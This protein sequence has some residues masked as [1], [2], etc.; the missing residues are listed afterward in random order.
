M[1]DRPNYQYNDYNSLKD[2]N[3]QGQNSNKQG[4]KS[5]HGKFYKGGPNKNNNVE[6]M[7]INNNDHNQPYRHNRYPRTNYQEMGNRGNPNFKK[8]K[9]KKRDNNNEFQFPANNA[10]EISQTMKEDYIDQNNMNLGGNNHPNIYVKGYKKNQ[11]NIYN[12]NNIGMNNNAMNNTMNN[13]NM[14]TSLGSMNSNTNSTGTSNISNLN[15]TP[16]NKNQITSP[17]I[18]NSNSPKPGQQNPQNTF[19]QNIYLNPKIHLDMRKKDNEQDMSLKD[20][21]SSENLSEDNIN[22]ARDYQQGN[23]MGGNAMG[24][25]NPNLNNLNNNLQLDLNKAQNDFMNQQEY[26]NQINQKFIPQQNN[27]YIHYNNM[28][29]INNIN[30]AIENMGNLNNLNSMNNLNNINTGNYP[31]IQNLQAYPQSPIPNVG[32]SVPNIGNMNPM[33]N[34]SFNDFQRRFL[35]NSNNKMYNPNQIQPNFNYSASQ[36]EINMNHKKMKKPNQSKSPLE[37]SN[38]MNPTMNSSNGMINNLNYIG[39][40]NNFIKNQGNKNIPINNKNLSQSSKGA[41]NTNPIFM[42]NDN[43]NILGNQNQNIPQMLNMSFGQMNNRNY[44]IQQNMPNMRNPHMNQGYINN[45]HINIGNNVINKDFQNQNFTPNMINNKQKYQKYNPGT[46]QVQKHNNI[47][48]TNNQMFQKNKN[49]LTNSDMNNNLM[50]NNLNN[51]NFGLKPGNENNLTGSNKSNPSLGPNNQ[52]KQYILCLNI[53][54]GDNSTKTVKIKNSMEFNSIYEEL[55]VEGKKISDKEKEIIKGK[56]D[57][58]IRL[59]YKKKIYEL[60]I[61]NYTYKNLC[62]IYHKLNYENNSQERKIMNNKL[63]FLRK[64]KSFKEISDILDEEKKLTFDNVR[65]VGSLNVTF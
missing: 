60:S 65:N 21:K 22:I 33:T 2:P 54:L 62:E 24:N 14:N 48:N 1:Q 13:M 32:Q 19:P 27:F 12:N 61:N 10:I 11:N 59:L 40:K 9:K 36:D 63:Q 52:V 7:N 55:K 34:L 6:E 3:Q 45:N 26:I 29:G 25:L 51:K 20:D 16:Q 38:L 30:N 57:A 43:M 47:N 8:N 50:N 28:N 17:L 44:Y 35:D 56:I 4:K 42:Q 39:P 64:N 49:V 58:A 46:Y 41:K 23:K 31:Q 53:K 37:Q 18:Y 15:L 5:N